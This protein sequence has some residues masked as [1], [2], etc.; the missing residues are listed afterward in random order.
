LFLLI[1]NGKRK[2][3]MTDNLQ[4]AREEVENICKKYGVVGFV[5][6][7]ETTVIEMLKGGN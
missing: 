5:C 3:R 1:I 4:K 7:P 6:L 2:K